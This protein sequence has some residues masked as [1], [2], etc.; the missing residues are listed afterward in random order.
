MGKHSLLGASLCRILEERN[1]EKEDFYTEM[2]VSRATFYNLLGKQMDSYKKSEVA[3]I[4]R[5]LDVTPV[6]LG[7]ESDYFT[8]RFTGPRKTDSGVTSLNFMLEGSPGYRRYTERFFDT[9]IKNLAAAQKSFN[10]LDYCAKNIGIDAKDSISSQYYH[11]QNLEFFKTLE[12]K[13]GKKQ[14][15]GATFRYR[16]ILQLPLDISNYPF[17]SN[18][19]YEPIKAVIELLFDEAFEHY[20]RCFKKFPEYFRLFLLR[21]PMRISSYYIVDEKV[22]ISLQNRV[23]KRGILIPDLLYL[24]KVAEENENDRA[25]VLRETYRADWRNIEKIENEIY[26]NQFHV[27]TLELARDLEAQVKETDYEIHR[28]ENQ[29]SQLPIS[30]NGNSIKRNE[31]SEQMTGMKK[32]RATLKDRLASIEKKVALLDT[33]RL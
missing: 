33:V 30:E 22:L 7:L 20:L 12:E 13:L 23:D 3:V 17:Y 11:Q 27:K 28:Y 19:N 1:I 29:L 8:D 14:S 25:F 24:D 5:L 9:F 21:V 16:R 2:G 26:G 31:I 4:C 15:T 6:Q 32:K 10:V 18:P